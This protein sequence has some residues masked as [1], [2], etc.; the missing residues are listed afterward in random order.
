L[1]S[2]F[3]PSG[4]KC[5]NRRALERSLIV[6]VVRPREWKGKFGLSPKPEE[7]EVVGPAMIENQRREM[8]GPLPLSCQLGECV[9][10]LGKL[11]TVRKPGGHSARQI[12]QRLL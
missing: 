11:L 5:G 8:A 1:G 3:L 9:W 4:P 6:A 7:V 2:P 12:G 10:A